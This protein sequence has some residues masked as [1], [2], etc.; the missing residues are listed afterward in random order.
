MS[1]RGKAL[2]PAIC[3]GELEANFDCR[4]PELGNYELLTR[5]LIGL[6]MT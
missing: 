3:R 5:T 2:L 1:C 6:E 4:T